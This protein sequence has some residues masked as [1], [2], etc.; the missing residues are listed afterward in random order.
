MRGVLTACPRDCYDTCLVEAD[1]NTRDVK[2]SPASPTTRGF[3]C[4][5]GRAD[6]SRVFSRDRVLY[7]HVREGGGFRRITWEEALGIVA[8]KLR[9]VLEE[10]GP[11]SVLHV[12]YAGNM[13]LLTWYY[14]LRLWNRI[15][16]ARTDW[17]ICSKSG[18]EALSLHYGLSYGRLPE[19]MLSS[20]LIVFW[21]FNAAVSAIHLWRLAVEAR[22]KGA[23]LVAVDPRRSE[24]AKRS[25]LWVSPRPGSD[26]ALAYGVAYH[27]IKE[28]L[29]DLD[30]ISRYTLGFERFKEEALGWTP[31]RVESVTGVGREIVRRLAL[32][33]GELKPSLTLIGFGVQKR[34]SGADVVRAVSLLPAMAGVH[35]GFYYS[36]SRGFFVNL[37][38]LT[39]EDRYN[40]SRVVSQVALPDLVERGEFKFI[41]VYNSNPLLTLPGSDKL[42]KGFTRS[43]VF[44][45]VHET[46]WTETARAASVV[47]PAPTFYEKRDV[48]IPYAHN[49]VV[50][51]ER[52]IDPLGESRDEVWLTCRLAEKLGLEDI[53]ISVEEALRIALEGG[54]E[55]SFDELLKGRVLRLRYRRL[56]EYQT[57]SGKIEFYSTRALELGL[58]PLPR[59]VEDGSGFT[60]LNSAHPL[61]THTQFRDVYGPIPAVVHISVGDAER[62]GLSQGEIVE[63]YNER[64]SVEVKVNVTSDVPEGVLWCPREL[65]GLN[66]VPMNVL[67]PT[68]RQGIGGGPVFNSIRVFVRKKKRG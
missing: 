55:G 21:G 6:W 9:S 26:V 14:P 68:E 33:Y 36:N 27:L 47:L 46:H 61:Y 54:L 40:P 60:L 66:G 8:E 13:G 32:L 25:D 42:L 48:V 15:G 23:F 51:S 56:D 30:F 57:P 16:A 45:V 1:P 44:V 18:H 67:A 43:D 3:L 41:F 7:P 35:R 38:K 5:R 22:E 4:P 19:E 58:D 34:Y 20:K 62:V 64:G 29:V 12:E 11:S 37:S 39:L 24:T 59:L 53:C 17:S 28:G 63:L 2:P 50:Y 49:Y 52:I 65:V 31:D 10:Y